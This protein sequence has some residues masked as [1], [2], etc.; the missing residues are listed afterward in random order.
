MGT[1]I[2]SCPGSINRSRSSSRTSAGA[3]HGAAP[4]WSPA[5]RT[6][7]LHTSMETVSRT[8]LRP[9]EETCGPSANAGLLE[10]E[11]KDAVFLRH[12][13]QMVVAADMDSD[14]DDDVIASLDG[15]V[16]GSTDGSIRTCVL[17]NQGSH[18]EGPLFIESNLALAAADLDGDGDMDLAT[19]T[20]V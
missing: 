8:W 14:G 1:S 11:A 7:V 15:A 19:P 10:F 16:R 13:T 17:R 6:L 5:R 3:C 4:P 18:L 9:M 2:S 20:E 12:H